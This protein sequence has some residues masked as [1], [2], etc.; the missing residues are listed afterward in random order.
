MVETVAPAKA[1][2]PP[3]PLLEECN[4]LRERV[5]CLHAVARVIAA[6]RV[7]PARVALLTPRAERDDLRL[8]LRSTRAFQRDVERKQDFM[9]AAH[10]ESPLPARD[11][12]RD[13]AGEIDV[14]AAE[15]VGVR[16]RDIDGD[17]W[18]APTTCRRNT[19]PPV[20]AARE[21]HDG[22]RTGFAGDSE[23]ATAKRKK[24]R[25]RDHAALR[26]WLD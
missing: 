15:A 4:H 1:I 25:R 13:E 10:L 17:V 5:E 22:F 14:G 26:E 7:R 19:E 20:R 11:G 8:A 18:C 21:R 6:A 9:K 12:P 2:K 3:A 23:T 24:V 16:R